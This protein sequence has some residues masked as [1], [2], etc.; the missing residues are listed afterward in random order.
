VCVD[1]PYFYLYYGKAPRYPSYFALELEEPEVG[2][3]LRFDSLSKVLSA[4]I[5]IGFAS[6]PEAL[7]KAI[8][9]HVCSL[10][11]SLSCE[12]HKNIFRVLF[13]VSMPIHSLHEFTIAN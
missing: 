2:H 7:L 9:S 4:G 1:D 6:G 8:D 3:V 11:I 13:S 5:R 10:L 12:A